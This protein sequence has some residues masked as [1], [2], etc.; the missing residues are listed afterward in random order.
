MAASS[1]PMAFK[2]AAVIAGFWVSYLLVQC[3]GGIS[4]IPEPPVPFCQGGQQ[5]WRYTDSMPDVTLS[6]TTLAWMRLKAQGDINLNDIN[7]N[8]AELVEI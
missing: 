1:G 6:W 2:S 3:Q 5:R 4:E 7:T 8:A